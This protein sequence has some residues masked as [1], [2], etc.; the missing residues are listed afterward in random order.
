MKLLFE[1]TCPSD[2]AF[3]DMSV[4][5]EQANAKQ[6]AKMKIK[7]IYISCNL[8]NVN[9]RIYDF[10][11]FENDV[12]PEYRKTWVE[13][14]RAYA[15]L[16]H[17]QSHEVNPK[18]ACEIITSLTPDGTNYIGESIILNSDPRTGILGTPNGDIL[19]SILMHGG[20][21]GK[22]TRGAVDDPKNKLINKDNQ[23]VLITVDTVLNPSGIG[24]YIN[25]VV[26]EQK[27]FMVN[28]HGFLVE[29]AYNSLEKN[30][31][32]YVSTPDQDKKREYM[33]N[34]FSSFLDEIK[35]KK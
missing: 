31:D 2:V 13:P 25:D 18:D 11:Y 17:A 8:K 16:N 24:C 15:E 28:E 6:P 32:A 26:L 27:D 21:I 9:G 23:Y 19:A 33:F 10:E 5:V 1:N 4:I 30:L 12:I 3:D 34:A 20:K 35:N 22:S 29:C 7:G 14:M